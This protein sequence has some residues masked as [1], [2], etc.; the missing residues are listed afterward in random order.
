VRYFPY[1]G[2]IVVGMILILVS[3]NYLILQSRRDNFRTKSYDSIDDKT[4]VLVFG[5]SHI[6]TSIMPHKIANKLANLATARLDY[7]HLKRVVEHNI[8]RATNLKLAIVELGP[9]SFT[10]NYYDGVAIHELRGIQDLG[11]TKWVPAEE[12]VFHPVMCFKETFSGLFGQKMT[13]MDRLSPFRHERSKYRKFTGF[14]ARKR[15]MTSLRADKQVLDGKTYYSEKNI[16]MN[17][18]AFFEVLDYFKSLSFK[19]ILLMTP[20]AR[21]YEG[22]LSQNIRA[23][24]QTALQSIER[25]HPAIEVW[26]HRYYPVD[27]MEYF[28]DGH[29][30]N[31]RGAEVFSGFLDKK[32]STFL[33]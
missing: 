6:Y 30:T 22:I 26:D 21:G 19:T 4:E 12:C 32:I 28:S 29:H 13:P 9:L 1:I 15:I 20:I 31:I 27:K 23:H 16:Q 2:L 5:T 8:P 18:E 7:V 11:I 3:N 14:V 24:F 17:T 33:N 25:K 10:Y